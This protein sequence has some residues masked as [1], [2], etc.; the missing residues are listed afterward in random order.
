MNKRSV[1]TTLLFLVCFTGLAQ[2][3]NDVLYMQPSKEV[4]ETGEDLWFKAYLMDR[5]T[6]ALSDR[7]QTLYLLL[8]SETGEVVWNEKYLLKDG[9]GDGHVYIGEKWQLG[10][11]Q[12]EGY[13][14][15]S[16]TT[17]STIAIRPRRIMVVNRIAQMDSISAE[18]VKRDSTEKLSAKHR[19]DLFPEGGNLI[20]DVECVVAFKATY[21]NGMPEEV[22]GV[23][24]EDGREITT[25]KSVHGGMGQF[26]LTPHRGQRCMGL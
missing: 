26:T 5:Q 21:G 14:R 16:F 24:T 19:F 8:R 25:I 1:I 22:V 20:D 18:A 17:D 2:E 10:E 13:T 7:S 11:Y 12:M 4:Y 6:L 9:R 23:V 3:D 15:S